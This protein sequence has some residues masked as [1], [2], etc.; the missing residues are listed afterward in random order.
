[1]LS[2]KEIIVHQKMEL[3]VILNNFYQVRR[4]PD[5]EP[6]WQCLICSQAMSEEKI[7]KHLREDHTKSRWTKAFNDLAV[8]YRRSVQW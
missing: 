6:T 7:L 3:N 5:G 8:N 4:L 2:G 1:M